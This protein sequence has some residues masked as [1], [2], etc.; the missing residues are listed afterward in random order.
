MEKSNSYISLVNDHFLFYTSLLSILHGILLILK[1]I[2]DTFS[3]LGWIVIT[4][5]FLY[6]PLAFIFKRKLFPPFYL[7]YSIV[8]T[9]ILAFDKTFLY[10]NYTALF[11]VCIVI[12]VKPK[13]VKIALP[14]YFISA[15]VAF[16]LNEENLIHFFIYIIRS[17]WFVGIVTFF[18]SSEFQRKKL[19]LYDDEIK[20]LE[21]LRSGKMY[22]KEVEGFS[23]NTVYRKLKAAR[24][25]NGNL[26]RDELLQAFEKLYPKNESAEN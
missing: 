19:V 25:R 20:I 22:Q 10:N 2:T 9:F 4:F 24:E 13:L 14:L 15:C 5:D 6:A 26:T 23:E 21:Q 8:L 18:V 17:A 16:A 11:I 7:L 1:G 3:F 12:I